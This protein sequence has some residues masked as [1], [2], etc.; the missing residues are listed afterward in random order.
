MLLGRKTTTNKQTNKHMVLDL[1]RTQN[2]DKQNKKANE[3]YRSWMYRLM[4]PVSELNRATPLVV[5]GF[6]LIFF[7]SF[8][9]VCEHHEVVQTFIQDVAPPFK[10]AIV[11]AYILFKNTVN[12]KKIK[13]I[14]NPPNEMHHT[15]FVSMQSK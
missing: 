10:C 13:Y 5:T 15:C 8:Y 9:R 2:S 6:Y 3:S 7:A 14:C 12:R 11:W 4:A 1:A